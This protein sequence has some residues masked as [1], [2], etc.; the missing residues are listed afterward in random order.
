MSCGYTY[1]PIFYA[2]L[3]WAWLDLS[4][5]TGTLGKQSQWEDWLHENP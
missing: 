5:D 3:A 2:A 1:G 4:M